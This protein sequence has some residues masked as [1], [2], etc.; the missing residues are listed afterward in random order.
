MKYEPG[1]APVLEQSQRVV[2][3]MPEYGEVY[4]II[5]GVSSN[6]SEVYPFYIVECIDGRF[7]NESY[8]YT[9]FVAPLTLIDLV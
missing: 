7:P 6:D 8:N 9:T 4:G 5:V 3:N 2:V 1:N